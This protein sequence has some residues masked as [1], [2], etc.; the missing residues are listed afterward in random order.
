MKLALMP[1]APAWWIW[2]L[3]VALL[4]TGHWPDSPLDSSPPQPCP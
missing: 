1:R 2:L 4:V 3:T